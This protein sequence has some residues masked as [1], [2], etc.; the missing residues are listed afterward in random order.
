MTGEG[1]KTRVMIGGVALFRW[2]W[3]LILVVVVVV[4]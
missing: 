1:A 3:L 2:F 4:W